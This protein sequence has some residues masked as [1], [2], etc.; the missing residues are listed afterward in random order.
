MG[1]S[2]NHSSNNG[3]ITPYNDT[4][5]IGDDATRKICLK[6]SAS[7]TYSHSKLHLP[8]EVA[9]TPLYSKALYGKKDFISAKTIL[10]SRQKI[11]ISVIL[12]LLL[13]PLK[14]SGTNFIWIFTYIINAA[15]ACKFIL[16]T[17]KSFNLIKA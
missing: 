11:F 6:D 8:S 14:Y 10:S 13:A 9:T 3:Y 7:L 16:L 15:S 17:I 12:L 1:R 5:I 4:Y 2:N